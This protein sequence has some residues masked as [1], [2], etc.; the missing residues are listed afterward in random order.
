MEDRSVEALELRV[1]ELEEENHRLRADLSSY[2]RLEAD[3]LDR[4]GK[5]LPLHTLSMWYPPP[6]PMTPIT[7]EACTFNQLP[8]DEVIR[9]ELEK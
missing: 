3:A 9:N 4:Y 2:S 1:R 8:P 5:D 6:F 7:I